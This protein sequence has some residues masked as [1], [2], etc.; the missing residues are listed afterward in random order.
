MPKQWV[1]VYYNGDVERVSYRIDKR[2]SGY[3]YSERFDLIPNSFPE[4]THVDYTEDYTEALYIIRR[5]ARKF[6]TITRIE[7]DKGAYGFEEE[8]K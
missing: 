4:W 8:N 7:P 1:Y 2:D 5:D 3:Y 6:G